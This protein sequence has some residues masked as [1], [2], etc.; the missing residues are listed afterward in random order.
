MCVADFP[1][2]GDLRDGEALNAS[3]PSESPVQRLE[4][5][6]EKILSCARNTGFATNARQRRGINAIELRVPLP[7]IH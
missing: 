5:S 2:S 6:F 1:S 4:N 3:C 7:P